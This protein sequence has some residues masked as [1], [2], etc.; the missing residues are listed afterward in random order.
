MKCAGCDVMFPGIVGLMPSSVRSVITGMK[1]F[2][3]LC[4]DC[5]KAKNEEQAAYQAQSRGT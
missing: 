3:M 2:D 1:C 4:K 5:H